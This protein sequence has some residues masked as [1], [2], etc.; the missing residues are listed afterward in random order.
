M[1]PHSTWKLIK[2]LMT[3][4]YFANIAEEFINKLH[5]VDDDS[6]NTSTNLN[7]CFEC[8]ELIYT[9]AKDIFKLNASKANLEVVFSTP[10]YLKYCNLSFP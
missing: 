4:K 5:P 8:Q 9:K 6:F 3:S 10:S 1:Q 2:R 7:S